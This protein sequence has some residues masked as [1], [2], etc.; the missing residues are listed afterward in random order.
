MGVRVDEGNVVALIVIEDEGIDVY[1]FQAPLYPC[2][3]T[4]LG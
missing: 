1:R 3:S 4:R 2:C